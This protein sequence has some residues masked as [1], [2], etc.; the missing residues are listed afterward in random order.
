MDFP[1][2]DLMDEQAC[3]DR[4]IAWLH[5]DRL[6]YP[7]CRQHDR[8]GV[9]SRGRDP[10]LDFRCR[11]YGRVF[12]ASTDTALHGL[13]RRP[14]ELIMIIRAFAQGVPTAQLA[15]EVA[16]DRSELLNLRHRLQNLAFKNRDFLP[17]DDSA[18]EGTRPT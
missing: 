8:L 3:Y 15:R 9:H 2:T 1:I 12:N 13:R 10:V 11:N 18:L 17:L 7:R 14:G 6:A 5:P 16:C 4:L